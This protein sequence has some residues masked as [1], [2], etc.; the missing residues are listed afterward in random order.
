MTTVSNANWAMPNCNYGMSMFNSPINSY[1]PPM[2]NSTFGY[3]FAPIGTGSSSETYEQALARQRRQEEAEFQKNKREYEARK[4]QEEQAKLLEEMKKESSD[5]FPE[6]TAEEEEILLKYLEK[7][8]KSYNKQFSQD[9][10][11]SVVG[12]AGVAAATGVVSWVGNHTGATTLLSNWASSAGARITNITPNCVK[13]ACSSV[14]KGASWVAEHSGAARLNSGLNA[15]GYGEVAARASEMSTKAANA[16]GTFSKAATTVGAKTANFSHKALSKVAKLGPVVEAG[17]VVYEDWGDLKTAYKAGGKSAVKQTAQT[18][19]KAGAAAAGFWAG[20]KGGAALG[21][22]IGSFLGP[23]GGAVGGFIGGLVGGIAGAWGGKKLAQ[24]CV[25]EDEGER[26]KREQMAKE[27]QEKA[28]AEQAEKMESYNL[29]LMDALTY[30]QTD[31]ELDEATATVLAKLQGRLDGSG[32]M[33]VEEQ[34]VA[35]VQAQA[36]EQQQAQA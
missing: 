33:T 6:L 25:G 30:A 23:V 10:T 36:Q 3:G 2:Q 19:V 18:A 21:A 29:M 22:T 1:V 35:A 27:A 20:A 7:T 9:A 11:E 13:T 28:A 16:S 32:T 31:A 5:I 12:I 14:G 4:A 24:K 34:A 15:A 26:L 17:K 8:N